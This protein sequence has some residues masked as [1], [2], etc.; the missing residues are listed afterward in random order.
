M[1]LSNFRPA[2]SAPAPLGIRAA[3]QVLEHD[4]KHAIITSIATALAQLAR[5]YVDSCFL[6]GT[7]LL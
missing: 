5:A 6:Q 1:Q 2:G 4:L 3:K 7:C